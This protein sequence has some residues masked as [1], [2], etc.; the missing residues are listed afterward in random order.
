MFTVVA[1]VSFSKPCGEPVE[2]YCFG[3][4]VCMVLVMISRDSDE[5]WLKEL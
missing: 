4:Y 3:V 5:S 1:T 2:K